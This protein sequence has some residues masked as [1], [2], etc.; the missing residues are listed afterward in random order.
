MKKAL[1][2]AIGGI[3]AGA[4]AFLVYSAMSSRTKNLGSEKSNLAALSRE[5]KGEDEKEVKLEKGAARK[6]VN[7]EAPEETPMDTVNAHLI[8]AGTLFIILLI[9]SC[10]YYKKKTSTP[11][12]KE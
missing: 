12:T 7:P 8:V 10:V 9:L 3:A 5:Y 11:S 6:A 2:A 1:F 4:V